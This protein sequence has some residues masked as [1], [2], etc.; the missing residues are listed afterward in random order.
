MTKSKRFMV[1]VPVVS[2]FYRADADGN[3][4]RTSK[5]ATAKSTE[6]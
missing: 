1:F 2:V 4:A 3:G 5:E 6:V